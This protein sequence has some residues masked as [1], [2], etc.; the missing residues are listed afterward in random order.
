MPPTARLEVLL[1]VHSFFSE[2]AG[3][4][5]PDRLARLAAARGFQ[6]LAL[7]DDA[8]VGGAV[9]LCA[10][11]A[12][13]G[14]RTVVG[15]TVPLLVP[16]GPDG[17]AL[18]VFPVVL[19]AQNRA[20]YARLNVLLSAARQAAS[21][22]AGAVPGVPLADLTSGT[23]GLVLLTGARRGFPTVLGAARRLPELDALLHTLKRAFPRRM[24][25]QLYHDARPGMRR[26]LGFLRA[27]ARD[28]GLPC[29]A[30]PEVRLAL[31]DE[32]PLLDALTCARLG[33]DVQCPHPDRPVNDAPHLGTP[34]E[35][36]RRLPYA[37]ALH[38]ALR[39]AQT[40]H[41]D[42]RPER[43]TPPVPDLPPGLSARA[44]LRLRAEAGLAARYA[45]AARPA[46]RA[47]LDAELRTVEELELEGFFLSAAEVT[48]Y[49]LE[50][51]ILA[52]GRGSAAGSVLC[53]VLGITLSDP[54]RHDLLFERFLHTGRRTMPDVDIDIASSRRDQVLAWVEERWG[55]GGSGEA[56]VANRVTYRLPSAVQ[57][58]GRALGVPPQLRDRLTRALGRDHRHLRPHRAQ[59]AQEVFGEVLGTAPVARQLLRLLTLMEGRFFRHHAPHSGG[60]ILSALPL[61]QYSPVTRSSG[62]IR[63][64]TFDK[65]DVERLGLIKL[66]L[67]GLRMLG[68][69]ERAREDVARLGGG[70]L[71]FGNLPDDP[72]VWAQLR[73]GD[74]MALFQIESPAQT[75][76]TA[77]LRPGTLT[78]L[79]H[80]I[81][82]V[83]PGP[84]Q[85]GTVHP[86]VRRRLGEEAVPVLREPLH[87]ILRPTQGVLLFQEQVLRLAVQYAGMDWVQ[88]DRF[89]KQVSSAENPD[90]LAALQDA[91]VRGAARTCGAP[92]GEA[93]EVFGWCAAFRGYGFAESH[94]WA[95]AQHTYASA[96]LRH[97]HPAAYLAAVLTEAPGMW[98]AQTVVQEARRWG[99]RLLPLSLNRSGRAYHAEGPAAVRLALTAV[100]GVSGEVARQ[101]VLERHLGG[102][103][104]SVEDAYDRLPLAADLHAA[105][106]QAGA[107]GPSRREALYRL[108]VLAHARPAGR[109]ALLAPPAEP[110]DLPSLTPDEELA[111]DLHLSGV[112]ASPH[113]RLDPLRG[114]LR[115]LGC[116]PLGQLR[117]AE[118]A[119]V[120][121]SV[122]ARQKPPT[123]RGFAFFVLQ[124]GPDRVQVVIR[125]EL[126]EAHR[127]LLRDARA[128]L[129]HGTVTRQGRAVTLRAERLADLPLPGM[130]PVR[131][132]TRPSA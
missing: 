44:Y 8:G 80:Q 100:D 62:G 75:V 108:T 131:R 74:T 50:H 5:S 15:A 85:S 128:L 53:Y 119:W 46:A 1:D 117:H 60:V 41:L 9:D 93:R 56:M 116:R 101:I 86:Y 40:C 24:Y 67:L 22:G 57:D 48:D 11:G 35:W 21:S 6:G 99:V 84:I 96:Y 29:V 3:T 89:R 39:L 43:L 114:Q 54:V 45:R 65:D 106:A 18:D 121:G 26:L 38:N 37:D 105:L 126:W 132:G 33:I 111:L 71:D 90:D 104:R 69:L 87:G 102:P 129:V 110:P 107:Y 23:A 125:P 42:L 19:L 32:Y 28:H 72:G 66:D 79:A 76:M 13:L 130:T 103:Y 49:C 14:L 70:W 47:R 30:A 83:R 68:V 31:P 97:H 25:V 20:G 7:T 58:L 78:D 27:L 55:A 123:A 112:S 98:P 91:F 4:G 63:M 94:A 36:A 92:Q 82:L 122:V 52:A 127:Q 81:A 12:E 51:G 16:S 109:H 64:L 120:A 115:D 34:E 77:R 95:F 59:E 17:R 2:G 61:T 88:A 124:D 73:L 113:D 10:V 118:T